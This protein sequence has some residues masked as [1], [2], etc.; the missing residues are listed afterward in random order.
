[1]RGVLWIQLSVDREIEGRRVTRLLGACRE[2][3]IVP[4]IRDTLGVSSP[5]GAHLS[6]RY[7]SC[8]QIRV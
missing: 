7:R 8:P 5:D 4:P 2:L 3:R 6:V 1:M